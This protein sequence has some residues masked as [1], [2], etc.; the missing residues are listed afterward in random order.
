MPLINKWE[1]E[2]PKEKMI[3]QYICKLVNDYGFSLEQMEQQI[4]VNNGSPLTHDVAMADIVI[5]RNSKDRLE[6]NSPIIVVECK[7]EHITI[8][9][10]NYFQGFNYALCTGA[11]LLVTIN[12]KETRIFK[13]VNEEHREELEE[14]FNIPN[15]DTVHNAEELSEFFRQSS[16]FARFMFLKPLC[17]HHYIIRKEIIDFYWSYI[18]KWKDILGIP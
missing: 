14:I 7:A 11:P 15:A 9:K 8:C 13:V 6:L 18:N 10:A 12:L 4:K 2:N 16:A 17:K 5:W 1:S 3:Q